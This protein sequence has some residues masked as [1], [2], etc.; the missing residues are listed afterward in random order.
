MVP[1]SK[2][3]QKISW[4]EKTKTDYDWFKRNIDWGIKSS[5]FNTASGA[6]DRTA[7]LLGLY[8]IYNSKFPSSWFT[9]VT[10][11]FSSRKAEH[12][13]WGAKVRPANI[14]RPNIELL[15][16]EY[17]KRYF[18]STVVVK[19]DQ[20]YN[21]YLEARKNAIFSNLSQHFINGVNDAA[22]QQQPDPTQQDPSQPQPP[23]A[24]MDTGVPSQPQT[25]MPDQVQSAFANDFR[26]MLAV[27]AQTDLDLIF[28]DQQ[29]KEK[30]SDIMKDWLIAGEC[31]SYK[32]VRRDKVIYEKV[33][34]LELD[35]DKSPH[36]KY[37]QDG[38]WACRRIFMT[39]PDIVD[40]FYDSLSPGDI[41]DI[42]KGSA[43][44]SPASFYNYL[45]NNQLY[46]YNKM[47]VFHF[48]WKSMQEIGF[49]Q[50]A[51]PTTGESYQDIVS[52][53]YPV[54]KE[55]G[56]TVDWEWVTQVLEGYRI[57]D[58]IYTEMGPVAFQPNMISDFSKHKLTYN[59][60][61]FSDTH[62]DNISVAKLGLPFQIMY[63][64]LFFTME[65][66][67]AKSRGKVVL[68]DKNV[69]PKDNGWDE[70]KF[71][72]YSEAQGWGL[73]N[74][75]Q[76]GVD[77]SMQTYQV[78]DLS[79]FEH[80]KEL[81][82]L[83]NFCSDEYDAQLGITR[84]R[85]AETTPSDTVGANQ[86]A[87]FQSSV[88]TEMIFMDF[89][90]FKRTEIEGLLDCSQLANINGKKAIY[91]TDDLRSQLLDINPDNYC[92]SELGL[93]VV[94]SARENE[95]LERIRQSS[96]A[97]AQNGSTPSTIVEIETATNVSKLK[98]ILKDI[99]Q[100]QQALAAQQSQDEHE[101]EVE[102]IQL[103][104]QFKE[105]EN[106][107]DIDKMNQEYTR[108]EEL[109]IL[110]GDINLA[111]ANGSPTIDD[112]N[113][114]PVI[115][116]IMARQ[117]E[118][119]QMFNDKDMHNTSEQNKDKQEKAKIILAERQIAQKKHEMESK[120]RI[121]KNKDATAKIVARM[122]PKPS[123]TKKR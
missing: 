108:K 77:K 20:G 8:N 31:R 25:P 11:P 68:I 72:Y 49:L 92:Y 37:I 83:L 2:P 101:Q 106:L 93:M 5:Y 102:K 71:F 94:D 56:E 82:N 19:G 60:R 53:D 64:I 111:I 15:R 23:Q 73:I 98:G 50:G 61:N 91:T 7:M 39:V 21:S 62:A 43:L 52:K 54:N 118:R 59:G 57:G 89:D 90:R 79:T 36:V 117:N 67:I 85:K 51:D 110:Q 26:D 104:Q 88:I 18:N 6:T 122:K 40:R 123:A 22:G 24:G 86:S 9:H 17:E 75:N 14:I 97:F 116:E 66:T 46:Q 32:D 80:I 81:I 35:Y 107:L 34:P 41:D 103:Q 47:P 114:E 48:V 55:I 115:T 96:Q 78:M 121:A 38:S 44:S 58:Q 42:E 87:I 28:E 4:S 120:E 30:F 105:Y 70:E 3:L 13:V 1:T 33:S 95:A 74:R 100:K 16:G 119:D 113:G 109:V 76:Q 69:I 112:G 12:Q 27:Q 45:E 65:R 99:E 29:V 63:C 10:N 84:Q